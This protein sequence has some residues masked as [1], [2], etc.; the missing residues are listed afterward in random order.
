MVL[1]RNSAGDAF[2]VIGVLEKN[3]SYRTRRGCVAESVS[4]S[5]FVR[6]MGNNNINLSSIRCM[7]LYE[8]EHQ[9]GCLFRVIPKKREILN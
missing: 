5:T 7:C 9:W 6:L 4:S 8:N 1:L 2:W 3:K